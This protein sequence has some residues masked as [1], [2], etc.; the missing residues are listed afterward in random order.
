MTGTRTVVI[1][2]GIVGAYLAYE[3]ARR[4]DDVE[5]LDPGAGTGASTRNAGILALSY[6]KPMSNPQSLLAGVKSIIGLGHDLQLSRPLSRRTLWWMAQFGIAS[7]PLRAHRAARTIYEM[8]QASVPLYDEFS[9]REQVSLGLRRS[10]WLYVARSSKAL[11]GQIALANSLAGIGIASRTITAA[12]L[13]D[14]EPSLADG[15][16][17]GVQYPGDISFDPACVTTAVIDAARRHGVQ[18]SADE[19]VSADVTDARVTAVRTADG[20]VVR[21]DRFVIATGASSRAVGRL[22]GVRLPVEPGYGWSLVLPTTGPLATSTLMGIEDHVVVNPGPD[23]VRITGGMR[24]GGIPLDSNRFGRAPS[25]TTRLGKTGTATR[26]GGL[27]GSTQSD[28]PQTGNAW[29]GGMQTD[30]AQPATT[31]TAR[32]RSTRPQADSTLRPAEQ[33]TSDTR[34]GD[35]PA[36]EPQPDPGDLAALRRAAERVLP[37]IRAIDH[38]G[39]GQV[40]ARPMTPSGLPIIARML[41]NLFAVTGH[42]T[43]GMTLAPRSAVLASD[44]ID[45]ASE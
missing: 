32:T 17:G 13:R 38:P 31:R 7:R 5:V 28:E 21:A 40:G 10:G 37:A 24:F 45:R 36:S 41:G 39:H 12:E 14:V 34:T 29:S 1:G 22:F 16:V 23:S 15:F 2:G 35:T 3:R 30:E 33:P 25:G 19:V 27:N 9:Q 42:G 6:A 18:F 20:R 44:L 26:F 8:T 4:G 11:H 43:L